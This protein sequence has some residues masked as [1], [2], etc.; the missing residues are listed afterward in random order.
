VVTVL[1]L[2]TLRP[3]RTVHLDAPHIS[4]ISTDR[5][6]A[7]V[8]DDAAG[9]L[10]VLKLKD[11]TLV[12]SVEV[13]QGAHHMAV[14]PDGRWVWAAL[15]ESATTVVFVDVSNP[16]KP[17]VAGRLEPGFAVHDLAFQ[18]NGKR[19]WLAAASSPDV[20]VFD[21]KTSKLLFRVPGGEPPQHVVFAGRRAYV[22]SG[23]GGRIE[24]VRQAN[25]HV[26]RTA[27]VPYGSFNLDVEG[28]YVAV[29]SLLRGTLTVLG[30]ALRSSRT[31]QLAPAARDVA[32]SP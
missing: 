29:S 20:G 14:S 5:R 12:G 22:T 1:R 32:L 6:Y 4:E 19:V 3:V 15:S 11:G 17:R 21:F 8:T 2:P 23:Y 24:L 27:A 30:P 13:G 10:D 16:R 9:K 28:K 25:G 26:I 18:P 7:Y 31:V